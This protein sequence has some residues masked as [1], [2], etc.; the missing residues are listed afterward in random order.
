ML[1]LVF[2]ILWYLPTQQLLHDIEAVQVLTVILP[3][4]ESVL[5]YTNLLGVSGIFMH[6]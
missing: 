5:Q 4:W 6:K 2:A 3:L 1:T